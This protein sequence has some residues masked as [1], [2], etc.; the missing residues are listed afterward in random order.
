MPIYEYLCA[1]CHHQ[2]DLMQKLSDEPAKNCP[3]CQQDSAVKM[4]SAAAFQL[5]GTGWYATD[6]KNKSNPPA[7]KD[8]PNQTTQTTK[9]APAAAAKGDGA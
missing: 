9:A 3:A 7:K 5:K 2:F 4:V 8:E 6:F 1:S